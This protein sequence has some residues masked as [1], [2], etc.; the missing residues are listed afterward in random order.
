MSLSRHSPRNRQSS[1]S[2]RP[3]LVRL[4]PR[5]LFSLELSPLGFGLTRAQ[6]LGQVEAL[7]QRGTPAHTTTGTLVRVST[8]H[9][10]DQRLPPLVLRRMRP[11][12]VQSLHR[13][14]RLMSPP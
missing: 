10:P 13:P 9:T 11:F 1:S 4:P 2:C 5:I 7:P 6:V 3:R 12:Q 8:R 14:W